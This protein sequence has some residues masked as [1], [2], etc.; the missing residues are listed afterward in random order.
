MD[1]DGFVSQATGG[2]DCDD[3]DPVRYPEAPELCDTKDNDCDGQTNEELG[4][5]NG[6]TRPGNCSGT[7]V[8]APDGGVECNAPQPTL[9]RYRDVDNDSYGAK[10]AAAE[11]FCDVPM[12]YST[13]NTDCDDAAPER[14]PNASE[15]C[16]GKDDNCNDMDDTAELNLGT[17]CPLGGGCSG[18]SACDGDGGI[19]C[20]PVTPPTLYF[21][22][23]DLDSYGRLDGG[24]SLCSAPPA[25]YVPQSGDCDDGNPFTH[26]TARE[27]CDVADNDCDGLNEDVGVCPPGG[28]IWGGSAVGT[29][30][31]QWRSVS[32][33][34]DGGVWIVGPAN[35]RAVKI[36]SLTSF[37]VINTGCD[38][39]WNAVWADPV[40]GRA[41]LGADN[42]KLAIHDATAGTCT[43]PTTVTS[44]STGGIMGL[45][46]PSGPE[47]HAVGADTSSTILGKTAIWDGGTSARTGTATVAPLADVHGLSRSVLFAS[48]YSVFFSEPRIYRFDA[49]AGEWMQDQLTSTTASGTIRAVWVVNDHL[50]YAVGQNGS[51]VRWDGSQWSSVPF[52]GT[53]DLSGVV[54]F[55][56]NSVYT[57]SR[58]GKVFRYDGTTWQ[59]VFTTPGGAALYDIAA[60]SPEDIWIVGA[61]D[62]V[63]HW[64][65]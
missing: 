12:G 4:L 29:G 48:G 8:C 38:S 58:G 31:Q 32:L 5:G 18:G 64:P 24:V 7:Q 60:T 35:R 42:G 36:P 44:L 27:L 49:G 45:P 55:G 22:D 30:N 28:A 65:K 47:L 23:D 2:T 25:G 10:T 53:D 50:A 26:P 33:W 14:H 20:Q 59:P 57:V 17:S 16:N 39:N 1:G 46:G 19:Y 6:C 62:F 54:A 43:S 61:N 37:S 3:G 34:G 51:V 21:L 13:L 41:Y 9:T 63:G 52:T 11:I 15:T 56:R 40:T